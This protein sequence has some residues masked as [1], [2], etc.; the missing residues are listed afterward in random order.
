MAKCK[1]WAS[2]PKM[3]FILAVASG[4]TT[5]IAT[6]YV[7]SYLNIQNQALRAQIASAG[8]QPET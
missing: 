5:A 8:I 6:A 4:L 1:D 2:D 3:W 7:T